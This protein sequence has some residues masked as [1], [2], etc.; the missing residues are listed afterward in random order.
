[1][2]GNHFPTANK[3]GTMRVEGVAYDQR[4]RNV[5]RRPFGGNHQPIGSRL[6]AAPAA[7]T[8]MS[9]VGMIELDLWLLARSQ[10]PRQRLR[11]RSFAGR[12][13]VTDKRPARGRQGDAALDDP[14]FARS[15][16]SAGVRCATSVAL[17]V[18]NPWPAAHQR[19]A[20]PRRDS[21]RRPTIVITVRSSP[22]ISISPGPI[23]IYVQSCV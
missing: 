2:V 18:V 12:A 6:G 15:S 14:A 21:R 13:R 23:A 16:R 9:G 19:I 10:E 4:R 20:R 8:T 17:P 22:S 11:V 7:L 1:M 5:P 3:S